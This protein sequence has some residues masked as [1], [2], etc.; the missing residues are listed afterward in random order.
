LITRYR[1]R[2]LPKAQETWDEWRTTLAPS[3][4]LLAAFQGKGSNGGI[5]WGAYRAGYIR[6]MR[7][8]ATEIE[9]L[10]ARV[11][12]GETI[13]LLCAAS[14]TDERRCHRSVLRELI[15]KRVGTTDEHR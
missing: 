14:C 9:E 13:T 4:E 12:A 8:R 15:E 11:R 5:T 10:A 1:P 7:E 3:K 2:A 6:E